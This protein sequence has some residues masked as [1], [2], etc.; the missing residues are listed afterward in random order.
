M[1]DPGNTEGISD[2]GNLFGVQTSLF[3]RKFAADHRRVK[4]GTLWRQK[5]P[6]A[7]FQ[8]GAKRYLKPGWITN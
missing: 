1:R 7:P 2:D 4:N 6:R 8:R 5:H 3:A